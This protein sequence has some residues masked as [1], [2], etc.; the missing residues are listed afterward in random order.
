[1]NGLWRC[2]RYAFAP[3]YLKYCGPDKNQ[4]LKGYIS[5]KQADLGLKNL[6]D[7]FAAMHPYLKLIA[8]ENG[9]SDEFDDRVVSAYWL[10]NQLLDKVTMKGFFE[11][12][13]KRLPVKELKWFE[14]KLQPGAKPNHAFHVLNFIT[15]TGHRA[16]SHTVE[17]MD[18]CR[19]SAGQVTGKLTVKTDRLVYR[20]GKLK[21]VP[22]TK[23][24][25]DLVNDFTPGDWVT[26]HWDWVCEK[27][28]PQ[29]A[30]RLD[31]YT[32]LALR[33]ANQTI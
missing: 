32:A 19:I 17:S 4:E 24:V 25:K 29:E 5:H 2:A 3:N 15:R 27:I 10:G 20:A 1:M 18:H 12:T 9:I 30:K 16:V 7:D 6:L 8:R 21:L 22:A 13:K 14:A 31:K 28:S 33:L 11:H 23:T 26:L